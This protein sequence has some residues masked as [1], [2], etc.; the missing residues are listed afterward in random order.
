MAKKTK[1]KRL[2]F[3]GKVTLVINWL[4][5]LCL[6]LSNFAHFISPEKFVLFAFFGIAFPYFA[7]INILFVIYW[8]IRR[9]WNILYSLIALVICLNILT[10]FV[11]I[12]FSKTPNSGLRTPNS[13]KILSYNV[14]V[15]DV[16]H[17]NKH[18][19]SNTEKRN[20][21]FNYI[22][23]ESPDIMCLQEFVDDKTGRF[24]TLDTIPGFQKA[25][26]YH[27]EYTLNVRKLNYFGI[28]T[29]TIFP[30]VN[31]GKILF[32]TKSN[33]ICIYTDIKVNN[34]IIRVY[35]VHL[36]SVRFAEEDF[37]FAGRIRES[38]YSEIE[39]DEN[40]KKESKQ[41]IRRLR[42][43]FIKRAAQ[44]ELVSKH[45][46]TCPYPVIICGDFN[47]TPS[48]YAYYTLAHNMSDAFIESGNGFSQTYIGGTFPSFRIDYI[49][50]SNELKSGNYKID[51]ILYSD[52]YP[53]TCNIGFS[54]SG[55][56]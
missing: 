5:V 28:A 31:K 30:I 37:E 47:D 13:F 7:A 38:P 20:R 54:L 48:S 56:K 40:F 10:K 39:K 49:L 27:F 1:G 52:H 3:F 8:L 42:K 4:F 25:V 32:S 14:R 44:A 16:Y 51:N 41:I 9:R 50:Y 6:L 18:W 15:F 55:L 29:F 26:N 24:K 43:A 35:N 36:Q 12:N 53:I 2:L 46:K 19:V 23:Q 21:I 11:N 22:K 45:I 17:Y 34:R 33:N